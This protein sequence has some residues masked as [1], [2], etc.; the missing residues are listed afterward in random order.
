[1]TNQDSD[2]ASPQTGTTETEGSSKP[3]NQTNRR[4][5]LTQARAEETRSR[6][7]QCAR[8]V[9]ASRGFAASNVREIAQAADTTHSMITYHF[10]SKEEL[11]RE[12]VRDMFALV[13]KQVFDHLETVNHLSPAERLAL[14]IR[15]Y[16]RY[17]AQHPEHARITFTETIAGGERLEWMVEEFVKYNHKNSTAD[18]TELMDLGI[19]PRMP[20]PSLFY[21]MVGMIQLPFVLA[22]EARLAMGYDFMSEEAIEAHAEAVIKILLSQRK[23]APQG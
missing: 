14:A 11:W 15:L 6:I 1:M 13:Q 20:L 5:Q 3:G 9:F 23:S 21:S 18:L 10:G 4:R 2:E 16:T 7:L 8:E 19:L 22:T 12:S 17:S